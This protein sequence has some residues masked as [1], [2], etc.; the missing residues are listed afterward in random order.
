[1]S[2]TISENYRDDYSD[3]CTCE[4]CRDACSYRAGWFVPQQIPDLEAH[5]DRPLAE[6]IGSELLIDWWDGAEVDEEIIILTP[7]ITTVPMD[8]IQVPGDPRGICNT[9]K[10]K[11]QAHTGRPRVARFNGTPAMARSDIIRAHEPA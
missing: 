8:S 6:L 9:I 7:R 3:P 11:E 1:M 5:F 10:G 2:W 4:H